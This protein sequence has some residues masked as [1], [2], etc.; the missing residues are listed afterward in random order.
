MPEHLYTQKADQHSSCRSALTV[1]GLLVACPRSYRDSRRLRPGMMQIEA[2]LMKKM[3]HCAKVIF[4]VRIW[5]ASE[6]STLTRLV[7]WHVSLVSLSVAV[8]LSS[9]PLFMRR[10]LFSRNS[11]ESDNGNKVQIKNVAYYLF[12]W[13]TRNNGSMYKHS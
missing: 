8:L 10:S 3:R 13:R 12:F 9:I 6:L 7:T 2:L 1:G 4:S 11:S 5:T